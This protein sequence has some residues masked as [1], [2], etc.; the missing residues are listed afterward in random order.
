MEN[1][2]K[3]LGTEHIG[4]IKFTGIEGGFGQGKKAMLVQDVA[5]IHGK[6]LRQINQAINMNRNRF[7][8]GIDIIDLLNQ[9]DGFRK[10]ADENGW[11]GSNRT[12]HVY[13]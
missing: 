10:I 11:I 12:K 6:E 1:Q 2:L 5:L 3:V 8:D 4:N 9:S 7:K 13:V